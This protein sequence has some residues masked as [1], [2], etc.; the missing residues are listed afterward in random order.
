[1]SLYVVKCIFI[2]N[3][4]PMKSRG[5]LTL[6]YVSRKCKMIFFFTKSVSIFYK[7]GPCSYRKKPLPEKIIEEHRSRLNEDDFLTWY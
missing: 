7:I 4:N 2:Q 1:M 3:F 6:L 5:F